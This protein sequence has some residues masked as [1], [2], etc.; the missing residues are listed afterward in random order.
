MAACICEV[1]CLHHAVEHV[2]YVTYIWNTLVQ[3]M[4]LASI[5]AYVLANRRVT[6]KSTSS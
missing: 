5:I 4:F 1:M 3:R 2:E 6:S